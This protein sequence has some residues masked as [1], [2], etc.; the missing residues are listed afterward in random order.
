[1]S[2]SFVPNVG[3]SRASYD[4]SAK[5]SRRGAVDE[6]P[7]N[8]ASSRGLSSGPATV[9]DL[10]QGSAPF[11]TARSFGQ[12]A[13]DVR[14]QLDIQYS[15]LEK[16]GLP[17]KPDEALSPAHYLS[18]ADIDRRSL[19][20]IAS[21][22]DGLF[23]ADEQKM[24]QSEMSQRQ[25]AAMFPA[26]GIIDINNLSGNFK[27]GMAY[28][29]QASPEEKMS[30]QWIQQK[31]AIQFNFDNDQRTNGRQPERIGARNSLADM[32]YRSMSSLE[33][34]DAVTL[35]T[36][37]PRQDLELPFYRDFG[38]SLYDNVAEQR[39]IDVRA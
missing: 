21:N 32:L 22:K 37:D 25:S 28:L 31:A 1:M 12:V 33:D 24:A 17:V 16:Q 11:S 10:S 19:F 34:V 5:S 39:Q 9:V 35:A 30:F 2:P 13:V 4:V 38:L 26:G 6:Q 3:L 8:S 14:A 7:T 23:T 29:D 36:G 15:L 27:Q 20:A 18:Y